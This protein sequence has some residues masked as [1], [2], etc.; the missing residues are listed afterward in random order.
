MWRYAGYVLGIFDELLQKSIEDQEEFM[1]CSMLHQGSPSDIP[2]APTKK[3]IDAFVSQFHKQSKGK[4]P[5]DKL[6]TFLYQMTRYLNGNDYTTGME[7]EDLGNW[8]WSVCLIRTLG[9][10]FGSVVPRLPFGEEALFRFHTSR[11]RKELQRHGTPTGH[12]AGTGV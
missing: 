5:F 10:A 9:F 6:Q 8:H 7:I 11:V 4:L 2:G 1:L 12:G 3:F